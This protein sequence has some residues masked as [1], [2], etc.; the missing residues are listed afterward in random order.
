MTADDHRAKLAKL[1]FYRSEIKHEFGLLSGR[2]SAYLASQ[3]FLVI[4]FVS[5]MGNSNPR[6]GTLFTL[7]VPSALAMLGLALSLRAHGAI[8]AAVETIALW[9]LKQNRLFEDDPL[10]DD[11]RVQR[12]GA[13]ERGAAV[14]AVHRR[15]LAFSRMVPRIFLVA[16]CVFF[17]FALF[18]HFKT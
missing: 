12:P 17:S 4:A 8:E 15:S 10:M 7:I 14:D 13:S 1:E 3:S 2:V 5:A 11:Y 9:H 6:W 16:W 18:F